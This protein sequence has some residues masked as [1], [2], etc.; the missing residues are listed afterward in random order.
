MTISDTDAHESDGE[1]QLETVNVG[2]SDGVENVD[3][4]VGQEGEVGYDE[5]DDVGVGVEETIG[6]DEPNEDV[7]ARGMEEDGD[8]PEISRSDKLRSPLPSDK[9]DEETS[10]YCDVTKRV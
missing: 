7:E 8:S 10:N 4:E 9:E 6:D 3:E 5:E 2:V 1:E